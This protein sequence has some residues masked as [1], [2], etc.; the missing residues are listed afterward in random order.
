MVAGTGVKSSGINSVA[1]WRPISDEVIKEGLQVRL[2][3]LDT[4]IIESR[5]SLMKIPIQC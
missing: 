2:E 5:W 1:S 4:V 3:Y